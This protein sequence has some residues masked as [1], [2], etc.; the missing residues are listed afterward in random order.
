MHRDKLRFGILGAAH[1]VP[2]AL[3]KPAQLAEVAVA[4]IAAR[5]RARARTFAITHGN[6][7]CDGII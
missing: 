1:I 3:I 7:L 5:D 2:N 6:S 4:A